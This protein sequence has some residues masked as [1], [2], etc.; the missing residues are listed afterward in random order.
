MV[1]GRHLPVLAFLLF[2]LG[3]A[4]VG[5]QTP[6]DGRPLPSTPSNLSRGSLRSPL[7][8]VLDVNLSSRAAG[9]V[10]KIHVPE[11]KPVKAGQAIISL[12]SSQERAEL[13]QAEASM[14]GAHADM[15]RAAGEFDRVQRL[16]KDDIYSEKQFLDAKAQAAIAKSRYEQAA[17]AVELAKT[18]LAYRD[19]VSP[20]DGI[21]LK[22]NKLVGE[23]VDRYESVA[24]IVDVTSLEAVMFCDATYF[25]LFKTGQKVDLRILK[26]GEQQPI[27]TGQITHVDPIIDPSSGTFRVKIGVQP[28]VDA[29]A[30]LS[31]ILIPPNS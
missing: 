31:A 15:E 7:R 10:E 25:S 12:D 18:R 27:V 23:A 26:S 11:G 30:G 29:I 4:S 21:F 9:I 16:H 1:K 13:A 24:R 5:A 28:S 3:L 17:A 19:I 14:R 8:P 2:G 20:N 6:A 22:T